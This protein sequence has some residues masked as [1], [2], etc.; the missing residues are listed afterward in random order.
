M[1]WVMVLS[2][3]EISSAVQRATW[4]LKF[5][6]LDE[7]WEWNEETSFLHLGE[8]CNELHRRPFFSSF[9]L[10]ILVLISCRW[11]PTESGKW[12]SVE[13]GK[14][15]YRRG[16]IR[17]LQFL[18]WP[19]PAHPA[20]RQNPSCMV[21]KRCLLHLETHHTLDNS[22]A[23]TSTTASSKADRESKDNR[24]IS[25]RGEPIAGEGAVIGGNILAETIP[26]WK[27][28]LQKGRETNSRVSGNTIV[29]LT[30]YKSVFSQEDQP[31]SQSCVWLFLFYF[32]IIM[33]K[34]WFY[35]VYFHWWSS[36]GRERNWSA[37]APYCRLL[38][39]CFFTPI[40]AAPGYGESSSLA[41]VHAIYWWSS[42]SKTQLAS[43]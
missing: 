9:V 32:I 28:C 12:G 15:Q 39:L 27:V 35:G 40:P 34:I 16:K 17:V 4:Q 31:K 3:L 8:S 7:S 26:T 29:C 14:I 23:E 10:G 5:P 18:S 33:E 11:D 13:S 20:R 6:W 24:A 22:H 2:G 21:R 19:T 1:I 25:A 42:P 43:H 38:R 30:A 37:F 41:T 36:R